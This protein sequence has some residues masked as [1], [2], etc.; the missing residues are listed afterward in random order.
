M[1]TK[2]EWVREMC[3]EVG[4]ALIRLDNIGDKEEQHLR[5]LNL[6]LSQLKKSRPLLVVES[7]NLEV[8]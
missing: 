6:R 3:Q 5:K 2:L 4:K 8:I 7:D 1:A